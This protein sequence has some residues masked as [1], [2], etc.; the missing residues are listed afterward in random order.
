MHFFFKYLMY[1][2]FFVTGN[3]QKV[4]DY[5]NTMIEIINENH[6]KKCSIQNTILEVG[7][8]L[9][10][11]Q[12]DQE[13]FFNYKKTRRPLHS[14]C[15]ELKKKLQDNIKENTKLFFKLGESFYFETKK[16]ILQTTKDK[17]IKGTNKQWNL[18][19]FFS[20]T[21]YIGIQLLMSK[22]FILHEKDIKTH[23]IHIPD[24]KNYMVLFIN[25]QNQKKKEIEDFTIFYLVDTNNQFHIEYVIT[26]I[27]GDFSLLAIEKYTYSAVEAS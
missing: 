8:G 15:D 11:E 5:I 14:L 17:K 26:A 6:N 2:S 23:I 24:T 22:K 3:T 12:Q 27:G 9:K 10:I 13:W 25:S 21:D 19:K 16:F 20:L 4:H 1:P 18:S 7:K